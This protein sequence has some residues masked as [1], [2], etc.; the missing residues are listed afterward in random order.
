[1]KLSSR[2]PTLLPPKSAFCGFRFPAEVIVVAARWYL[3]FNLS[4]R[5][6]EELLAERGVEADHATICSGSRRCCRTPPS[7]RTCAAD[8]TNS[9]TTSH[10]DRGRLRRH[11]TRS[12][13]LPMVPP[14]GSPGRSPIGTA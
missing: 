13:D 2:C 5:D 7:S 3:R 11:R 12:G 1:V 9:D 4:Y 8:T 14:N 6:V 10:P